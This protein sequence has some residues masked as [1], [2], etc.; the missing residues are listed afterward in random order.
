MNFIKAFDIDLSKAF[1]NAGSIIGKIPVLI[2]IKFPICH[3][4]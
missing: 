4:L 3:V 1:L 2:F